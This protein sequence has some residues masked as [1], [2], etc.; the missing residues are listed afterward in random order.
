VFAVFFVIL[1][2]VINAHRETEHAL[3]REQPVVV[4]IVCGWPVHFLVGQEYLVPM[5]VFVP[6]LLLLLVKQIQ[7]FFV[8]FFA[9][10]FRTGRLGEPDVAE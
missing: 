9:V 8:E 5:L 7:V 3:A 1:V 4:A 6:Q 2:L 10:L